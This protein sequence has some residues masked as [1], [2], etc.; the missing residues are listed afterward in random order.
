M[1]TA[2]FERLRPEKQER[3]I[4][5]ARREFAGRGFASAS[6]DR[7]ASS[8]GI[9]KGSI[10]QYFRNKAAFYEDVVLSALDHTWSLFEEHVAAADPSDCFELF[11]EAMI[12]TVVLAESHPDLA[13]LYHRVVFSSEEERR[14]TL[15]ARYEERSASFYERL[16]SWGREVGLIGSDADAD[17]IRFVLA[18]TGQRFQQ[19]VLSGEPVTEPRAF[20]RSIADSF[21]RAFGSERGLGTNRSPGFVPRRDEPEEETT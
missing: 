7:I 12:F 3:I 13:R 8:A 15:H 11:A 10:Y 17:L 21:R 20:A 16:F 14:R 5:S 4:A 18:A 2:T 19:I 9:P 1:P 6:L